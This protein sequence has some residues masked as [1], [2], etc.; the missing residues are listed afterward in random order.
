[1]DSKIAL[2]LDGAI[3]TGKSTIGRGLAARL[4][5]VFLDGDD[6]SI[7]GKP[8]YYS[9]LGTCRRLLATGTATLE[10]T[11]IVVIARPVRCLDWVF[12][13]KS[14]QKVGCETI[15]VG[16]QSTFDNIIHPD[17]GRVFSVSERKRIV[18]MI[19]QG[20]GARA[21]A[22]FTVRTDQNGIDETLGILGDK[23]RNG[24]PPLSR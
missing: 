18:E 5:G 12:F 2:L 20:Y 24:L 4:G 22:Q 7:Q 6:F 23:L 11:D 17:R 15:C 10:K 8:W 21:F 9:S 1:M 14:F 19:N 13:S 3:G 16:L